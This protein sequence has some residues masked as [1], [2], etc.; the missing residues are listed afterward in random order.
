MFFEGVVATTRRR[1]MH[2]YTLKDLLLDIVKKLEKKSL[3]FE[4]MKTDYISGRSIL[5]WVDLRSEP[6]LG[7]GSIGSAR[8]GSLW[9]V[10]PEP[11]RQSRPHPY[12]YIYI[13]IC[14]IFNEIKFYIPKL[15]ECYAIT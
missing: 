6:V 8:S 11:D 5:I 9:L 1:V 12:I 2:Y 14:I 3:F 10:E 15:F 4:T 13:Y 7:A